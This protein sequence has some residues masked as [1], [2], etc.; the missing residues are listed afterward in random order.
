MIEIAKRNG[1]PMSPT[2]LERYHAERMAQNMAELRAIEEANAAKTPAA[3]L[4]QASDAIETQARAVLEGKSDLG[5]LRREAMKEL[6]QFDAELK[7]AN[8]AL[9]CAGGG[10]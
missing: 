3:A 10:A 2:E 6:E 7:D 5:T 1:E 8:A 9:K 4:T